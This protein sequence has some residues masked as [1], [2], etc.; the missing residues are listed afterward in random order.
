M[1]DRHQ[2][3]APWHDY[4]EGIYFVTICCAEKRHYFGEI[5][6]GKM[7][8][9]QAGIIT[10]SQIAN[11]PKHFPDIEI[12]NHV[13]MP[14]HIHIIISIRNVQN[15][16]TLFKASATTSLEPSATT[17]LEPSATTSLEPSAATSL[18]PSA[19]A[20]L[21][22][23]RQRRHD[24]PD[25][26]DFHHN[27]RLSVIIRCLKGGVK[28]DTGRLGISFAWQSR[29]Y[30]HIIRNRRAYENI[31]NYIDKNVE[32]WHY[33]R[34]HPSPLSSTF[35]PWNITN[36]TAGNTLSTTGN[37]LSTADALKSV[38]TGA[39]ETS[40][41]ETS[42]SETGASEIVGTTTKSSDREA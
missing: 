42:A 36:A 29:Y 30:E 26:Q 11:L 14:N 28:R 31:M 39:S 23:L 12:W 8:F 40:A 7:N 41:S 4:N 19:A 6:Q 17:S 34:F 21:G 2:F 15:V 13:V 3:R 16:G 20:N 18:E 38:P 5:H 1:A 10:E 33:D 25:E 22:C 24:A 27:T 9:T 35:A 37:T 32:N